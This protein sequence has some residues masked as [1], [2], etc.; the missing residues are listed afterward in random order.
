[1]NLFEVIQEKFIN[2]LLENQNIG[3]GLSQKD[4]FNKE[5]YEE[6]ISPV[7]DIMRT[8]PDFT[9]EE[10]RND[11]FQNSNLVEKVL[12]FVDDKRL[13]PCLSLSYG[14][15]NYIETLSLSNNHKTSISKNTIYDLASITKLFTSISILKLYS[16]GLIDLDEEI[17]KYAPEFKNLKGITIMDLLTFKVPLKTDSR[18][19]KA[20]DKEQALKILQDIS[21]DYENNRLRPY[22]DMGAMVLK[23]VVEN[24]TGISMYEY[25]DNTILKNLNMKDTHVVVP[26]HK[27]ERVVSTSGAGYLYKDG[28]AMFKEVPAGTVF[29]DKAK[30]LG[31]PEGNLSGHAGLF[32]TANDMSKLAEALMNGY[33]LNKDLVK[34]I[35]K[36]ET[37]KTVIYNGEDKTIQYLGKLVF[38]KNPVHADSE[39]YHA[40]S[41]SS[42][43]SQGWTGTQLTVDP[44]NSVYAFMGASKANNR[45]VFIDPSQKQKIETTESGARIVHLSNKKSMIDSS[46]FAWEKDED[47]IR[48]ALKLALQYKYLEYAMEKL[49]Y[50]N[51]KESN[52]RYL[53]SK[54]K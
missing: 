37:G 33:V 2:E 38:S 52:D 45:M 24:V 18:I 46:R 29:D 54:I 47:I 25:I 8:K 15:Q 17:V 22:T 41:A 42:F 9:P 13:T 51:E 19:D 31:Q 36:N 6:M 1:M 16:S 21:I 20:E 27:L 34:S 30:I 49:G 4:L 11:I 32:S 48:P 50:S 40:L 5:Q 10:I 44:I 23:Y 3:A 12:N 35:G 28:N 39:V 26:S 53:L 43:A 7:T 14:T